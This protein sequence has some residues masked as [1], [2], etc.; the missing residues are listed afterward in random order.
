MR[1]KEQI[2]IAK[3]YPW[4]VEAS[5]LSH[6]M[7]KQPKELCQMHKDLSKNIAGPFTEKLLTEIREVEK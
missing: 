2:I 3:T 7:E 4:D 6:T 1:R 5:Q